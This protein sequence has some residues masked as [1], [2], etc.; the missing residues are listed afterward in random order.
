MVLNTAEPY[1]ARYVRRL[2][3]LSADGNVSDVRIKTAFSTDRGTLI[4]VAYSISLVVW[5]TPV[6][7]I[8]VSCC[9]NCVLPQRT[10]PLARTCVSWGLYS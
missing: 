9:S 5:E 1:R 2:P 7:G 10:L 3:A 6:A 8:L 4:A